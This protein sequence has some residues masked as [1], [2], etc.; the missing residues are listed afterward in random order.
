MCQSESSPFGV[1]P[2][3]SLVG[4]PSAGSPP[5]RGKARLRC[6]DGAAGADDRQVLAF[7]TTHLG[8]EGLRSKGVYGL[9]GTTTFELVVV[10]C[11][12]RTYCNSPDLSLQCGDNGEKTCTISKLLTFSYFEAPPPRKERRCRC[13]RRRHWPVI[14]AHHARSALRRC[15]LQHLCFYHHHLLRYS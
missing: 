11:E 2:G 10:L 4:R 7:L 9:R 3:S 15:G 14:F 6:G 13:V 5:W 1:L 8:R 12:K